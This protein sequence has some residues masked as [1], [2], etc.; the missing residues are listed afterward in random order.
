[1]ETRNDLHLTSTGVGHQQKEPLSFPPVDFQSCMS[2]PLPRSLS[3]SNHVQDHYKTTTGSAH[4]YK[5]T[6]SEL[7][8]VVFKK[9]PG[10]WKVNYTE[11]TIKKIQVKPQR[12][13]LTMGNE[14]SEMKAQYTGRP[15]KPMRMTKHKSDVQ[16]KNYRHHNN[17]G[18]LK[19]L[20]PSTQNKEVAG[21]EYTVCDRGVLSYHGDMYLTST[22]KVHRAFNKEHEL[23]SYPRKEYGTYWECEGYPKAWGHGAKTNPLPPDSVP[24]EK[25]PMRDQ[26]WFKTATTIPRLPKSLAPLKH[27]GMR[28]EMRAN[29]TSPDEDKRKALFTCPVETPYFVEGAGVKDEQHFGVPKMYETE[30][31]FYGGKRPV[32]V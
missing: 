25:G 28:S 11:D 30:A 4:N 3:G 10:H 9:A 2:E 31:Q 18:P 19:E 13:A 26:I 15:E 22:Q 27:K 8:N 17:E 32:M 7:S 5:P 29:F 23:T 24:R 14:Q 6:T 1:M 20:V 16:P 12:R 21:D